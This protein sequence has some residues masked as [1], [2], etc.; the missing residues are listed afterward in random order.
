RRPRRHGGPREDLPRR[1][2]G[3]AAGTD[4]RRDPPTDRGGRARA[5]GARH[6]LPRGGAGRR[7]LADGQ[8]AEPGYGVRP[9]AGLWPRQG[10]FPQGNSAKTVKVLPAHRRG[11]VRP[12]LPGN[13]KPRGAWQ[14]AYGSP[15]PV[16]WAR[17]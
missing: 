12:T 1:R 6:A 4:R 16:P 15:E 7:G 11:T 17:P 2:L 13:L 14:S 10:V 8:V 9:A 3:L 5:G